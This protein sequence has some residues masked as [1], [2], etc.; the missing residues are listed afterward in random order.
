MS[1]SINLPY[2][3]SLISITQRFSRRTEVKGGDKKRA[4]EL[5]KD[6]ERIKGKN[7][8]RD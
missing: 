8:G 6:V 4:L 2:L 7:N 3:F 5:L 1:N